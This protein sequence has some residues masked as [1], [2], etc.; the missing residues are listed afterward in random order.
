MTLLIEKFGG[1]VGGVLG[2][3]PSTIV[4]ASIGLAL[5]ASTDDDIRKSMFAI[6]AGMLLS[7]GVLYL[8]REVPSRFPP[9]LSV[10]TQLIAMILLSLIF[11]LIAAIFLI[12]LLEFLQEEANLSII[13]IGVMAEIL[14]L[15]IGLLVI[16]LKPL[17]APKGTKKVKASTLTLRGLL[18]GMAI[19]FSIVFSNL[20][21]VAAG[22]L[23]V[24]PAIF[25]TT[26]ISLWLSQ[27]NAV[28][29]GAAGPMMLGVFWI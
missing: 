28:S 24:F 26:M 15:S 18:A 2:T 7:I 21:Q 14:L 23:S 9:S 12:F 8:W 11:W 13:W 27:G 29:V 10:R 22:I 17:P 25:I 6:P 1:L 16:F 5:Q 20:S 4:P 19:F 3:T